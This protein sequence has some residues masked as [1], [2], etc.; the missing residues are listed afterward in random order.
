MNNTGDQAADEVSE[1]QALC[2]APRGKL[3][4]R[5]TDGS[6][7]NVRVPF[8]CIAMFLAICVASLASESAMHVQYPEFG[9]CG[10]AGG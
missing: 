7:C 3:P 6:C 9:G 5:V 1:C 4:E 2:P 8:R 10:Q